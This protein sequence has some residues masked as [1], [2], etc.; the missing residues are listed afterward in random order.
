MADKHI[1]ELLSPAG[2][3]EALRAALAGGADAVYFGGSAF[4]N[5]MRAKNFA[6]ETIRDAIKLC[7]SV[8]AAAHIT[9]NTR[10]SDRELDGV[11][12]FAETILGGKEDER[13]DALIVA[14]LGVA[15]SIKA[16]FPHAVLHGSTQ[17]SMMSP[18]DCRALEELGFSRLVVPREMSLDEIRAL[19]DKSP[20]EIEMFIHGAH[21]VSCSGQCLMSYVMGGRSGNRGECAQPCRLPYRM[22]DGS[23]QVG[24]DYPLS[25][26]DMMLG[27]HIPE[28]IGS[29]VASLKIEGR[30]KSP[31]YVYGVTS[32]YRRLLDEGRRATKEE[33]KALEDLFTRGFT[34]G[35]FVSRYGTMGGVKSSEKQINASAVQRE[36]SQA[37]SARQ[38]DFRAKQKGKTS[39]A[40]PVK[41]RFELKSGSP[42]VFELYCGEY[43]GRAVGAV[44]SP[45]TGNPITAD[46]AAKNLTKL[47]GSG[48][49]LSSDDIEFSLDGGLWMPLSALNAL[50]RDAAD[51]LAAQLGEKKKEE[52]SEDKN[53]EKRSTERPSSDKSGRTE[54]KRE[55]VAE[56]FS[57]ALFL[58]DVEE[59]ERAARL[60]EFAEKFDRLYIPLGDCE[61]T[62]VKQAAR[63]EKISAVLPLLTGKDLEEKLKA[64][65][66]YGIRRA[67]CHTAGQ[68]RLVRSLG[69]DG[70]ISFRGN[71]TNSE[72]ADVYA[73]LGASSVV[74]S[75]E[76]TLAAARG[77]TASVCAQ[78]GLIVYGRIPVM[79]LSRCIIS[80]GNC[81]K[82]NR[83]GRYVG[84]KPH[85]CAGELC[86]R[87]GEKFPVVANSDC[88]NVIYN[89][90]PIWMGDRP[91]DIAPGR[92]A[93]ASV[94]L[95]TVENIKE[96]ED[97]LRAYR[98]GEKRSGR[99]IQ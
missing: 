33:T 64:V 31:S 57:L 60:E 32:I 3:E 23:R 47:G 66:G 50:R 55:T 74:L 17:T 24:G 42:A 63:C 59:N 81:K 67:L 38:S 9:V 93:G 51:A 48:F 61:N 20:I 71:V 36:I 37:F 69:F 62:A 22:T 70:D 78:T 91:E 44:P 90:T 85:V 92:N 65:Y 30:L 15:S 72:A 68:L 6:G 14:D 75:P 19:V 5:R 34:D 35:Y 39:D 89:S 16:A 94:F 41:A 2:S 87:L 43:V 80:G 45:S 96:A 8:G 79:H 53:K 21:C 13:A 73:S 82:G 54:K 84:A 98:A 76:V 4:S 56:I 29:G 10:V 26:A 11:L 12:A 52:N 28:I 7:H 88:T 27:G 40:T 83:G 46:S 58:A 49:S 86:D 18:D 95:F 77:I 1:P 25:L 97:V 99:R